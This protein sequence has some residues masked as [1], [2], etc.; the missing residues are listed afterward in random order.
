MTYPK[1]WEGALFY[2]GQEHQLKH[3]P[4]HKLICAKD[5]G[6]SA[7]AETQRMKDLCAELG[8]DPAMMNMSNVRM[9]SKPPERQ[10]KALKNRIDVFYGRTDG[11]IGYKEYG[12]VI[13]MTKEIENLRYSH[14]L[15]DPYSDC[16]YQII[17]EISDNDLKKF[18]A[19]GR[20]SLSSVGWVENPLRKL[21]LEQHKGEIEEF[22]SKSGCDVDFII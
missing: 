8:M 22:I 9:S 11:L 7:K 10:P 14:D 18:D 1:L 12:A 20:K 16:E 4:L 2:C 6:A 17:K 13:V 21:I 15:Y 3:W 19:D 5:N